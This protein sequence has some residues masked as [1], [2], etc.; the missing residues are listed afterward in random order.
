MFRDTPFDPTI[1][2]EKNNHFRKQVPLCTY[3]MYLPP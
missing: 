2:D 1:F 3:V